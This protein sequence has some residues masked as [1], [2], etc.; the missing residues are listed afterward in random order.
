MRGKGPVRRRDGAGMGITPAYAGKSS[1]YGL[2]GW[3]FQD[4]PRVCGEK[5]PLHIRAKVALGSP[6]RMRGKDGVN[7]SAQ[8]VTGITPA[9]AG[10]RDKAGLPFAPVRDHP[11]VCGEKT[12]ASS[13]F[14]TAAGSPPRV[15]GK[16]LRVETCF[17]HDGITPAYAGKR[18]SRS[19]AKTGEWDHPRVCGEK[20]PFSE[21]SFTKSGS[22]PRMRGKAEPDCMGT[23]EGGITPAYAGKR[24]LPLMQASSSQ[25]HP[26]VCGEK[27]SIS[28]F[29]RQALGSPPRMRGKALQLPLC[30]LDMRITPAYA[31][32]SNT[33]L[34]KGLTA[35]D[36]PRVCGEKGLIKVSACGREGS[37]PRMRGKGETACE[38][39]VEFGITP[40]CA[41]KSVLDIVFPP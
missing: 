23:L 12:S 22:P 5:I 35:R 7:D 26:R 25:D 20:T 40:A 19:R 18:V 37:P 32:K 4:H 8:A 21:N 14:N 36:H 1:Q 33:F 39:V 9:C 3:F 27:R 30:I 15:R 24:S 16:E 17:S 13:L 41:G 28:I 38:V 34:C 6:P 29:S 2:R 31:G 10:K 11:R